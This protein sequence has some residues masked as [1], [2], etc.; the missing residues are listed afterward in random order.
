MQKKTPYLTGPAGVSD[1][2]LL[3]IV[4]G[5]GQNPILGIP[6]LL[7]VGGVLAIRRFALSIIWADFPTPPTYMMEIHHMAEKSRRLVLIMRLEM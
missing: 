3:N 2:A 4:V 6:T 7:L 5:R 1:I